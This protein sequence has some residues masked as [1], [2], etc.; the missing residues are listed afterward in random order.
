MLRRLREWWGR[1]RGARKARLETF[2]AIVQLTAPRALVFVDRERARALGLAP[3]PG[4]DVWAHPALDG[5]VGAAPMRAPLE[6]HVQLT[7]RCDAGCAG[8][9]TGA[10]PEGAPNELDLAG[11][12]RVIDELAAMGVF[13][14]A[15]GGGES[16][17]LPW[18]GDIADHARAR[19]L[20]PNLTTSGLAG[21][22]RL[23]PI[24][25]RFG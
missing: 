14:L 23:L 1:D 11:W 15:L 18:L 7:N 10:S 19:G 4:D 22:E 16:A 20:V 21:L 6:A 5:E 12:K 9:Y 25:D 13:H 8:C 17:I 3:K 2:G 24:V